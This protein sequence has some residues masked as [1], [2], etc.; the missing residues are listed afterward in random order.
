MPGLQR[1]G[2]GI[3]RD[4]VSAV[5]MVGQS[6]RWVA[7][8]PRQPDTPLADAVALLL[9][10]CPRCRLLPVC[11]IAALGP[12]VSQLKCLT[13]LPPIADSKALVALVRENTGRFFLRNGIPLLVSGVHVE[14]PT[15]VWVAAVD[16]PVVA[17]VAAGC[18]RVG[19]SLGAVVP[20]AVALRHAI[21]DTSIAWIDGDVR[22]DIA[23]RE[24]SPLSVRRSS[25]NGDVP[26]LPALVSTLSTL[27]DDAVHTLDAAGAAL[28][29]RS[30]AISVRVGDA[31]HAAPSRRRLMQ[32]ALACFAGCVVALASPGIIAIVAQRRDRA[33]EARIE[34][35]ARAARIGANELAQ[36]T[37]TLRALTDYADSRRSMVLLLAE[38]TRSLPDSSS[39]VAFQVDSTGLGDVVAITPHAADVVDAVERTPGLASPQIIGP[40]T[41]ERIGSRI[42]DRVTVRFQIVAR[43]A[44]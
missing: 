42:M 35:R 21:R 40:V 31:A 4:R 43:G 25:S 39:L 1:L 19:I 10:E 30:E 27:G 12:S 36:A 22:W 18:R 34:S 2:L 29:R 8:H 9:A 16:A 3:G 23:F 38:I 13:D 6:V 7:H 24:G 41:R 20:S 11:A 17:D 15:R 14:S 32:A 5:L 37:A 44:R 26:N 33:N 28:T